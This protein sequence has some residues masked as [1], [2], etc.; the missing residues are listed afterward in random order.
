MVNYFGG[1]LPSIQERQWLASSCNIDDYSGTKQQNI[2]LLG[3]LLNQ[4]KE[5]DKLVPKAEEFSEVLGAGYVPVTGY[6]SRTTQYI[7]AS[8]TTIPVVATTDKA[9]NQISL[10]NISEAN[11]VKVYMNLAPGTNKEEPILCTGLTATSWTGCTRG[12]SFQGSS[13]T[14]S[15][16]IAQTHNA[17]TPIIITNIAQS[18]NQ[19]ISVDGDQTIND[20]KTFSNTS[21]GICYGNSNFCIRSNGSNL[22]W[23]QDGFTSSYNFTSSSISTLSASTT[24]GIGI[25]DSEIYVNASSTTGMAFGSD[26]AL[27]QKTQSATGVESDSSGVKINTSTLTDLIATSTPTASKIPLA[28]SSGELHNDWIDEGNLN[29]QPFIAGETIDSSS[30]PQAVYFSTSTGQV[31]KTDADAVITTFDFIGFAQFGQTITSGNAINV[32]TDG[33]VYGF[34]GLTTGTVY[35]VSN[36]AGGISTSAGTNSYK[37]GRAISPTTLLIERGLKVISGTMQFTGTATTI[38]NTGFQASRVRV[39]AVGDGDKAV[40]FS[41]GGWTVNG[42]DDCLSSDIS[43][44]PTGA[45]R[46]T[47]WHLGEDGGIYHAG[48]ITVTDSTVSFVNTETTNVITADLFYEIEG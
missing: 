7:S 44:T 41:Q 36:V 30:T 6:Q 24:A 42:G 18:H 34:T 26:G 28:N 11:V 31:L 35:Y 17:G 15:S 29:T 23:T 12:L 46:T 10:S 3:C 25:T 14:S 16:T 19:Y 32:Q 1:N 33:L 2:T 5:I 43:G 37:I 20:T 21:T 45:I 4:D 22:Q 48:V 9:G 39:H 13:E 40:F 47:A 27:Y 38:V 8:A